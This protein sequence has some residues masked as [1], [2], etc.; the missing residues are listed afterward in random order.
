MKWGVSLDMVGE[1]TALTGG[2]FLIEKMPDPSAV[3]TRGEDQH[4]EWYG[5]GRPLSEDRL[6]PHYFNDYILSRCLD[7][8]A[9]TRWVVKTNPYEGGSDHVPFLSAGVPGLLL[10]HFTDYFYHTDADR[11]DKVS[12]GEMRNVGVSA[13]VSALVLAS[14]DGPTALAII[15]EVTA[16]AIVRLDTE[17]ALSREA[18]DSGG[19]VDAEVRIL[20][21]WRDWYAEAIRKSSDIEVGGASTTTQRIIAENVEL[22]MTHGTRLI[23]MLG[24]DG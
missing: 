22:V 12:A 17:Y 11:I 6:V 18:I 20:R 2:A 10:W 9:V 14:A 24:S 19:E 16:A 8:A 5:S 4:T 1:N 21:L 23:E 13:I 15:E 3:V 7:Q